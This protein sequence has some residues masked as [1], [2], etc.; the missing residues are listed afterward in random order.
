M[1]AALSLFSD[2]FLKHLFFKI[3]FRLKIRGF[4]E[5]LEELFRQ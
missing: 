1:M 5:F 3:I 4:Y 2:K